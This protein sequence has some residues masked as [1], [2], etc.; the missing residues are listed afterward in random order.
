[1][2]IDIAFVIEDD[3][4][5]QAEGAF[6]TFDEALAEL[7]LRAVLPWD[8]P[9]NQAPCAGWEGCGRHYEVVEYDVSAVP[10]RRLGRWSVLRIDAEGPRWTGTNP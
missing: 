2:A 4:H 10:W 7:R 1:M 6:A 8:Q 3:L 5:S 9:P